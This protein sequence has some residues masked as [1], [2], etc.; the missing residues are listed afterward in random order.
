VPRRCRMPGKTQLPPSVSHG[1]TNAYVNYGCRCQDCRESEAFSATT[2]RPLI[3]IFSE[4]DWDGSSG[5]GA[6]PAH[7][8]GADSVQW[9]SRTMSD[10][11]RRRVGCRTDVVPADLHGAPRNS[12]APSSSGAWE[13]R[14]EQSCPRWPS[15]R[16]SNHPPESR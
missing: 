8:G 4:D 15:V 5:A 16:P 14:L 11:S 3:C 6:A 12:T 7:R 10:P 13:I 2:T 9:A 1:T